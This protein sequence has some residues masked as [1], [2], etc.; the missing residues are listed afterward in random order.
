MAYTKLFNSI[1]SS[2]IWTEDDQTRIV[3]VTLMA[4]ADK[5]GE[6]QASIPGLA[7]LASV[8]LEATEAA[9]E[10]FLAPDP[11][12]RTKDDEGRRIEEIDGGWALINHAKYRDMASKEDSKKKNAERQKRFRD[13]NKRNASV[14]G[15]NAEVTQSRDIAEADT[16]ADPLPPIS[17]KGDSC[18]KPDEGASDEFINQLWKLYPEK[19]RRRSS[20]KQMQDAW[21]KIKKS[22]RPASEEILNSLEAWKKTDDWKKEN[23]QFVPGVHLWIQNRQ[24]ENTPEESSAHIDPIQ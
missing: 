1:I 17:P 16:E 21:R 22:D 24:W 15:S 2:T 20:K 23:G 14:T 19:G 8:P 13:R 12:S 3:W 6:V 10:K 9:I 11:Y 5:N 7:R 18:P 4:M